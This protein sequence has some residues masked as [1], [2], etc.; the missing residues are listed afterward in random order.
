[1]AK[2]MLWG[3]RVNSAAYHLQDKGN[4]R[5]I[6][7][8]M[9][10]RRLGKITSNLVTRNCEASETKRIRNC[11]TAAYWLEVAQNLMPASNYARALY[12]LDDPPNLSHNTLPP[13]C[14]GDHCHS[15]K[16]HLPRP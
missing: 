14:G 7:L 13:D 3:D 6:A 10:R 16:Q 1:M 15:I 9:A 2:L 11:E 12:D 4:E 8:I 5:I